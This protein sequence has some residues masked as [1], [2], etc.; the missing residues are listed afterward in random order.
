MHLDQYRHTQLMGQ[1]LKFLHLPQSQRRGDQ[2]N[3]IGS[4]GSRFNDLIFV[5]YE[6]FAQY[7]QSASCPSL[8]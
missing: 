8:L 4:H 7:R 2:Q 3:G 6:V 5:H 1:L